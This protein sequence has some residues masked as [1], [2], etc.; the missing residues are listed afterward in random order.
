M[1]P[2]P[3]FA[4][5]VLLALVGPMP[6]VVAFSGGSVLA[7]LREVSAQPYA[8]TGRIVEVKGRRAAPVPVEWEIVLADPSARGGVRVVTVANARIT[9][10]NTP[11]H[12]FAGVPNHPAIDLAKV[13]LDARPLFQVVQAETESER[14]GFHWLDYT[15]RTDPST[16]APV[17]S[18]DLYDHLSQ[19]VASLEISA[20]TGSLLHPVEF[21]P[22]YKPVSEGSRFGGAVGRTS[23]NVGGALREAG[24]SFL[25]GIGDVQEYLFGE[26]SIGHRSAD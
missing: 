23:E 16:G 24:Q 21:A 10:E 14:V 5:G 6:C 3:R 19:P 2:V 8:A 22:G 9:S 18:V 13:L 11:L 1:T 7:A 15:L 12:G 26:R 4:L 17:W 25:R 20:S